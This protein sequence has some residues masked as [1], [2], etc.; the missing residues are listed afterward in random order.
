MGT[1]QGKPKQLSPCILLPKAIKKKRSGEE[2]PIKRDLPEGVWF[3]GDLQSRPRCK[4]SSCHQ[5][6]SL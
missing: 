1:K 6:D 5:G 2:K 3:S 4:S